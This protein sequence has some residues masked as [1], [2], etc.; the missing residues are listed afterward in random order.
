MLHRFR[1]PGS[2]SDLHRLSTTPDAFATLPLES[3]GEL[4]GCIL[5]A[6]R[7]RVAIGTIVR[8]SAT[9]VALGTPAVWTRDASARVVL[10]VRRARSGR[11]N[12]VA[13]SADA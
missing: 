5:H 9:G 12:R 10:E 13:A 7:S 6:P 3:S 2:D 11:T 1:V 8:V 4:L